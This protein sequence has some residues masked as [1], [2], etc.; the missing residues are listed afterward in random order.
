M[1]SFINNVN[2]K[3][4]ITCDNLYK[5]LRQA[6]NKRKKSVDIN[7]IKNKVYNST[8]FLETIS[9]AF[10]FKKTNDTE[11]I[12]NNWNKVIKREVDWGKKH[13]I[14][15]EN[16]NCAMGM[17]LLKEI[18]QLIHMATIT[19]NTFKM[20][21]TIGLT[22]S[23]GIL[24]AMPSGAFENTGMSLTINEIYNIIPKEQRTKKGFRKFREDF[25]IK[26]TSDEINCI[27]RPKLPP[28][29]PLIAG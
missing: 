5:V 24:H 6:I 29:P 17:M 19:K 14:I 26:G 13:G 8:K 25:F 16:G 22:F 23:L 2:I 10:E 9:R 20:T 7:K 18:V 28:L 12:L 4:D 11:I 21:P 27:F 15:L 1:T 3:S